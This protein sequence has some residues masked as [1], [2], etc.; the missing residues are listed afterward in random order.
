[1]LQNNICSRITGI[2]TKIYF[3]NFSYFEVL[4]LLLYNSF[5]FNQY[6]SQTGTHI[7]TVDKGLYNKN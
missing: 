7:F 2:N 5:V 1:M 4:Y 3:I 6:S